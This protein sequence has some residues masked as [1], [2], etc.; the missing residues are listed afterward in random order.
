MPNL[1]NA[2]ME[3][4]KTCIHP[5][6]IKGAE[7]AIFEQL[8]ADTHEKEIDAMIQASGKMGTDFI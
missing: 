7:Q 2:M 4:R 1:N 6:L 8:H 3:L 5:F